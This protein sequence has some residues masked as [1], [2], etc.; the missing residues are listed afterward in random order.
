[1]LVLDAGQEY[2]YLLPYELVA[3]PQNPRTVEAE[4]IIHDNLIAGVHSIARGSSP[5]ITHTKDDW[6]E[7]V[8]EMYGI[9]TQT[10]VPMGVDTF[11]AKM[12]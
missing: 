6:E 5:F 4:A 1:M 12:K 8:L 11:V 2:G 9:G 10:V 3:D 7:G